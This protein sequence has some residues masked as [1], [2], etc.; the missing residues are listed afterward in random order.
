[1]QAIFVQV[2]QSMTFV[3]GPMK[4]TTKGLKQVVRERFGENSIK[5]KK[6]EDLVQML[7]TQE[8]FK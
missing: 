7:E 4:G 1:M 2:A 8:D 3:A 5:G 6:Q